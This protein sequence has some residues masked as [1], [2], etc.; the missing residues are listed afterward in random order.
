MPATE[1]LFCDADLGFSDRV[2]GFSAAEC[3]MHENFGMCTGA[4]MM[5]EILHYRRTGEQRALTNVSRSLEGLRYAYKLG[6]KFEH[7]FFPKV[8]GRRFSE[9]TSTDQVLYACY[10]MDA[11]YP[12]A[13]STERSWIEEM[14]PSMIDFWCRRDYRYHYFTICDGTWQWPPQR[15]PALLSLAEKYSGCGKFAKEFERMVEF[16]KTPEHC[17][18][19]DAIKMNTPTDFEKVN[20]G[21]LTFAGADRVTMETMNY[22]IL[23]KNKPAH[24]F[25]DIWKDGIRR[26][27]DEVK[28]TLTQDGRY[29]SMTITDFKNGECRRTPGYALDGTSYHGAKSSWSTMVVRAGLM[30]LDFFPEWSSEVIPLAENVLSKLNFNDCTYYD[31]PERFAPGERF[32]TKLLS[33][34]AVTNWLWADELLQIAKGGRAVG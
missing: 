17:Q 15:F 20:G 8:Y 25:S 27:W 33:G 29:L 23:L 10:A 22:S 1:E 14:I 6:D 11:Y 32:K 5:S 31:E 26:I 2:K 12:L 19:A 13:S 4:Y 3:C 30:A 21:W 16:S 28:V 34:D 18:L 24:P 7:G 9:E